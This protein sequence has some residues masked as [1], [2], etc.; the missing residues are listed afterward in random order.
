MRNE[1]ISQSEFPSRFFYR[2]VLNSYTKRFIV[3]KLHD[4]SYSK[5]LYVRVII[6]IYVWVW[7]EITI[8]ISASLLLEY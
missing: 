8:N 7:Y 2:Y 4:E 5:Q 1:G 6:I 3:P